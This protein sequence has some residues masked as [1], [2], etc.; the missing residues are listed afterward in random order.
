M[1]IYRN[2]RIGVDKKHFKTVPGFIASR[3]A[4]GNLIF[5]NA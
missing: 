4:G 5:T 2:L 3:F 1:V